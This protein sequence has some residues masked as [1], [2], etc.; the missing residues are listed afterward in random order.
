MASTEYLEA[1]KGMSPSSLLVEAVKLCGHKDS[2]LDIGC[3]AFVD[4]Y[5]LISQGFTVDALD[6]SENVLPYYKKTKGLVF[7]MTTIEEFDLDKDK[8]DIINAQYSLGFIH[9]SLFSATFN[10]ILTA[11]SVGGIFVGQLFGIR[12]TWNKEGTTLNFHTA[13]DIHDLFSGFQI[14]KLIEEEKDGKTALG[15]DKHWHVFHFIVKK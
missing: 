14:I 5:F 10:E 1:T 4:S 6:K 7:S 13:D 2:A 9:P 15:N 3:G 11:L 8:Y 12:D